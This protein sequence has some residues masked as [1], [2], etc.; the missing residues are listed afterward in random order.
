MKSESNTNCPTICG[1]WLLTCLSLWKARYSWQVGIFP[2]KG[3]S[4]FSKLNSEKGHIYFWDYMIITQMNFVKKNISTIKFS[5]VNRSPFRIT[6]CY[7]WHTENPISK[8]ITYPTSIPMW[9]ITWNIAWLVP[10]VLAPFSIS[11]NVL[12]LVVSVASVIV[13]SIQGKYWTG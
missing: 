11:N 5:K 3:N 8:E 9:L 2:G 10:Q 13:L 7:L 1:W 6:P 4:Y 12:N